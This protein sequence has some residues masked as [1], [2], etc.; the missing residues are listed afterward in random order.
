M[1][2][3]MHR[4]EWSDVEK[5]MKERLGVSLGCLLTSRGGAWPYP[6]STAETSVHRTSQRGSQGSPGGC[7]AGDQPSVGLC[8]ALATAPLPHKQQQSSHGSESKKARRCVDL[9]HS[10]RVARAAT[11]RIAA[12]RD[13]APRI[14]ARPALSQ[15]RCSSDQVSERCSQPILEHLHSSSLKPAFTQKTALVTCECY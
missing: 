6:T 5:P 13:S 15:G 7:P 9:G 1:V 3:E 10:N 14:A 2:S 11:S 4:V 12:P 8:S